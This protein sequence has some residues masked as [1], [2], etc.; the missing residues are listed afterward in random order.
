MFKK[1]ISKLYFR[2]V[3]SAPEQPVDLIDKYVSSGKIPW[4][5]GYSEYRWKFISEALQND[6]LLLDILQLKKFPANFGEGLD[7]RSAE[8]PWIF[9]H[10]NKEKSK[11]L[12]A[13]STFN[14]S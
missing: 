12:D 13:G 4:S 1:I 14:F 9:A 2:Y 6:S 10:L 5:P 3:K 8:Y 7:D 11:I